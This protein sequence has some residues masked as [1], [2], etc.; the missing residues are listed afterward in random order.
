MQ[1][2]CIRKARKR[3][4]RLCSK[5]YPRTCVQDLNLSNPPVNI[6]ATATKDYFHY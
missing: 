1:F 3:K 5:I 6:S 4:K 2:T